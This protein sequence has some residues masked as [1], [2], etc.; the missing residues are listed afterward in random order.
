MQNETPGGMQFYEQT[1]S[2]DHCI[3]VDA[4]LEYQESMSHWFC[5]AVR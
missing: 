5:G 1:Y 2:A 3:F 4:V